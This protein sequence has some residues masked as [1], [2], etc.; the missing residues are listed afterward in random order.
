MSWENSSCNPSHVSPKMRTLACAQTQT[1]TNA[2]THMHVCV[3]THT[4]THTHTSM[5]MHTRTCMRT[6]T[7]SLTVQPNIT[8]HLQGPSATSSRDCCSCLRVM[9]G[10]LLKG[11]CME[12]RLAIEPY[13]VDRRVPVL[14]IS[15]SYP[16]EQQDLDTDTKTLTYRGFL[17]RMVY[18]DYISL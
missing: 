12:S 18:L 6:H 9:R 4:N 5:R 8:N 14:D 2:C 1:H 13:L 10:V 11:S 16:C 15:P 3:H 7:S 17:T